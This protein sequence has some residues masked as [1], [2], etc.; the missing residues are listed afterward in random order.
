M[1]FK[2][3][4]NDLRALKNDKYNNIFLYLIKWIIIK[5]DSE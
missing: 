4:V 2:N 3:Y 1:N 5:G